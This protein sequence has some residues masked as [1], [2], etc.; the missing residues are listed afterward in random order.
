[1]AQHSLQ[2]LTYGLKAGHRG[3]PNTLSPAQAHHSREVAPTSFGSLIASPDGRG[4][5][6]GGLM[7]SHAT[8]FNRKLLVTTV[9]LDS[10]MAAEASMGESS[11]SAATGMPITL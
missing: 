2:E 8:Y 3:C 10:A 7:S 4:L 6:S 9:T 1:M 5:G 11:P